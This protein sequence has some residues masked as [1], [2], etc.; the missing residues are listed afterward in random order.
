M[1]TNGSD[2]RKWVDTLNNHKPYYLAVMDDEGHLTFANSQFYSNFQASL[3]PEMQNRFFDLVHENDRPKLNKS[4]L[5]VH[6][7][8]RQSPLK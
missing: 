1:K 8:M 3:P 4:L 7:A 2:I 6:C 5:P